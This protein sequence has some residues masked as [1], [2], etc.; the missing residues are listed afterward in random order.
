VRIAG[1]SSEFWETVRRLPFCFLPSVRIRPM[2][3][4]LGTHARL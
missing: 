2:R 1:I 3:R 4:L